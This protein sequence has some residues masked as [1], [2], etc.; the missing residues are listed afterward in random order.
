MKDWAVILGS[1]SGFG[2]ATC[3]ALAARGINI[4]G[5]HLDRKAAM[6]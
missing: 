6:D 1:S 2:A 5:I 4:Y 3:R